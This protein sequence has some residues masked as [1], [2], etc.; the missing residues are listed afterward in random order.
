MALRPERNTVKVNIPAA[1]PSGVP[2]PPAKETPPRIA[3]AAAGTR[4]SERPDGDA[5]ARLML[6]NVPPRAAA[7]AENTNDPITSLSTLT[8]VMIDALRSL[9]KAM[10]SRPSRV[11]EKTIPATAKIP[12][13][14]KLR[15]ENRLATGSSIAMA[16]STWSDETARFPVST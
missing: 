16:S 8:P 2:V 12:S 9:P 6:N 15:M 3:A 13:A 14:I 1:M 4:T 10:R 7:I 5:E 11:K